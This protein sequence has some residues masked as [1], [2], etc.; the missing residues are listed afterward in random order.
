MKAKGN[1]RMRRAGALAV[2]LVAL[3]LPM[4]C[5]AGLQPVQGPNGGGAVFNSK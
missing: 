5:T 3:L 2:A 1:K 4:G